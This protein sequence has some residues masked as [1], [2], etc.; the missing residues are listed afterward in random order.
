M[1]ADVSS[2]QILAQAA[3]AAQATGPNSGG[4]ASTQPFRNRPLSRLRKCV[5]TSVGLLSS[6]QYKHYRYISLELK[7]VYFISRQT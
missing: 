1:G 3:Q 6:N 4:A 7:Q 2:T 5:P